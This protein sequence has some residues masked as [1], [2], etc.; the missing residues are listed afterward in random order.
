MTSHDIAADVRTR[1]TL[2]D[3]VL[4]QVFDTKTFSDPSSA[5]KFEL[6]HVQFLLDS[7]SQHVA[8]RQY[9][10][11]LSKKREYFSVLDT[12]YYRMLSYRSEQVFV[13][14]VK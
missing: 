14:F 12:L 11:R 5:I 2:V 7:E 13:E 6:L 1:I 10:I 3:E 8:S 4:G 9:I